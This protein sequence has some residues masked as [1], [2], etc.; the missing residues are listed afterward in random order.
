[1]AQKKDG[2]ILFR[3]DMNKQKCDSIHVSVYKNAVCIS[4]FSFIQD[5]K[6]I[7][8]DGVANK[9]LYLKPGNYLCI[10]K[11]PDNKTIIFDDIT[12]RKKKLHFLRIDFSQIEKLSVNIN[13][14]DL[15]LVDY[16]RYWRSQ[17]EEYNSKFVKDD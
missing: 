17:I 10:M 8:K 7:G 14:S 1:M 6:L 4:E 12:I 3:M 15:Y 5:S 2:R 11:G 13:D 16:S 9:S